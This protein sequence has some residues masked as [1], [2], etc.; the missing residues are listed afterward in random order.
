MSDSN[1]TYLEVARTA[2]ERPSI[3]MLKHL[4]EESLLHGEGFDI[5]QR[6]RFSERWNVIPLSYAIHKKKWR[7][8][9]YLVQMHL[10]HPQW[11]LREPG[12]I[13]REIVFFYEET[14][15]N[16]LE[17]IHRVMVLVGSISDQN[18]LL[19]C[20]MTFQSRYRPK[21]LQSLI[22]A[23]ANV[24]LLGSAHYESPFFRDLSP[25][26]MQI[27]IAHGVDINYQCPRHKNSS[28]M[29]Y[30]ILSHFRYLRSTSS[31]NALRVLLAYNPNLNLRD[32]DG[33]TPTDYLTRDQYAEFNQIQIQI[34]QW[35]REARDRNL[36][37]CM[38]THARLGMVSPAHRLP[39][40]ICKMVLMVGNLDENLLALRIGG[41]LP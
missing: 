2:F 19:E 38:T 5:S 14:I 29:H 6:M 24:R 35:R 41:V 37:F 1:D 25:K 26:C 12:R 9:E 36:A 31:E 7:H 20:V 10:E 23:G 21:V 34:Q 22:A 15:T 30:V 13:L 3:D 8:A 18:T 17:R 33:K 32:I 4:V 27:F 40:D 28:P 39:S 16:D 11:A